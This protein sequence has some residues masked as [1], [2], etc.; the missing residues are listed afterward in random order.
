MRYVGTINKT[1]PLWREVEPILP[2]INIKV[3]KTTKKLYIGAKYGLNE[4]KR[5]Y[6][7]TVIDTL[8]RN[9]R[10]TIIP[11]KKVISPVTYIPRELPE[12]KMNINPKVWVVII[13]I[14]AMLIFIGY[15]AYKGWVKEQAEPIRKPTEIERMKLSGPHLWERGTLVK[16]AYAKEDAKETIEQK[17]LTKFAPYGKQMLV[18]MQSEN[19]KLN[20]TAAFNWNKNGTQDYGL[21]R[22][23]SVHCKRH[24]MV[25]GDKCRKFFENVDNNI[26]EGFRIFNDREYGYTAWYGKTCKQFWRIRTK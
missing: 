20:P 3:D 9:A 25:M 23:N 24:G 5:K 21:M 1:A 18:C 15:F 7:N 22:I 19:G 12:K 10:R 17:I 2:Y 8:E 14:I 4:M 11:K 6:V 26:D 16:Q 13:A